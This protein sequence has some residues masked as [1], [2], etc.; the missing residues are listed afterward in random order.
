MTLF[1][2]LLALT[3]YRASKRGSHGP[4]PPGPAPLPI[5]G[6]MFDVPQKHPWVSYEAWSEVYSEHA[7][8]EMVPHKFVP[9]SSIDSKILFMRQG[10]TPVVILNAFEDAF[11]LMERRSR[12]YSDKPLTVMDQ[13]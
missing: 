8:N 2:L 7:W 1:L 10:G 4:L 9:I 5:V 11:E 13:L 3:L 12:N 6:N